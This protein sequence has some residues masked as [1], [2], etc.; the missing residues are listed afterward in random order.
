MS[1]RAIRQIGISMVCCAGV[2]LS[3]QAAS[4]PTKNSEMHNPPAKLDL[5]PPA[6]RDLE[7]HP[8][9]LSLGGPRSGQEQPSFGL[10]AGQE[11][12]V[13][14][15]SSAGRA[16]PQR[17]TSRGTALGEPFRTP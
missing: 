4:I 12:V 15:G 14:Q 17:R 6:T 10:A 1:K 3:A 7:E 2:A 5:T 9:F 13:G 16:L 8:R 11:R